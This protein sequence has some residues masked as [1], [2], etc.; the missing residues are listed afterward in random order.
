MLF[1]Y[2]PQSRTFAEKPALRTSIHKGHNI[3]CHSRVSQYKTKEKHNNKED[4]ER[5]PIPHS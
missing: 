4:P 1:N 3:A 2:T 5:H